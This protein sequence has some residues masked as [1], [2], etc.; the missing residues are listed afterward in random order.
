V[1]IGEPLQLWRS[2]RA[3]LLGLGGQGLSLGWGRYDGQEG[4]TATAMGQRRAL[5]CTSASRG[6]S[7][8]SLACAVI[9]ASFL[10]HWK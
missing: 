1:Q 8:I 5:R 9:L 7:P 10:A 2:M 6:R 4:G 3:S